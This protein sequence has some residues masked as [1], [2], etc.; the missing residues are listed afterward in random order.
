MKKRVWERD[1]MRC[2]VCGNH[3][4]M[5]NAHFI[6]RSKG[7]LG[8]EQNIVTLCRSCHHEFDNGKNPIHYRAIIRD[9]LRTNYQNWMESEL[10]YRK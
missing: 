5:P 2:V 9:Y 7:G 3:E 8:I 4:A 6:R 10:V 1:G